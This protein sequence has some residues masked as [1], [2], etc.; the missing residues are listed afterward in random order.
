MPGG[1]SSA[2]RALITGAT[3]GIGLELA[4]VC[5]A[6][7]HDLILVSRDA[8]RLQA[9]A[10]ELRGRF[11]REVAVFPRDLADAEG[12]A[13]LM[14]AVE[15]AGLE[16]DILVNN[17]GF[18]TYGPYAETEIEDE[19][20]MMQLNVVTVAH[21]TRLVLPEM[22]RRGR[23]RILN[24]ASTAAFQPG[25]L[26]AIYY[27]GKAFV[28]HFSEALAEELRGSGVTVTALCPGVTPTGFQARAKMEDSRLL[29]GYSTSAERV[30]REGY[31]GLMAGRR[32]VIPGFL[33]RLLAFSVRLM[34]RAVITRI[35]RRLMASTRSSA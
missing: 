8:G 3:S 25:P 2:G 32:V 15:A 16:V 20:K 11:G 21:L 29:S 4:R 1:A 5:A 14:K 23:G 34:P 7:G 22:I 27:A 9:V 17:A 24:V 28:L 26:M 33:N 13:A 19:L 35:V 18:G 10:E 31:A 12:P 6:R 30:A